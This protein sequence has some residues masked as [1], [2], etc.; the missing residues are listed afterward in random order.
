MNTKQSRPTRPAQS[1]YVLLEA[2]VALG[3]LVG[4]ARRQPEAAAALA[5]RKRRRSA[6]V[7]AGPVGAAD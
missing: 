4:Y 6:G 2:L 5:A 1:G 3:L 7:S